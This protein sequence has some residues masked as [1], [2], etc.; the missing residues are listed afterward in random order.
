MCIKLCWRNQS[1][2]MCRNAVVDDYSFGFDDDDDYY[3]HFAL[4]IIVCC[5]ILFILY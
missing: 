4:F 5:G 2:F 1:A 3:L